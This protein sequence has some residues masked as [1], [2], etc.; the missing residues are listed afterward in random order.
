MIAAFGRHAGQTLGWAIAIFILVLPALLGSLASIAAVLLSL[1]LLP[2]LIY[3]QAWPSLARQPA[4][5]IFAAVFAALVACYGLTAR[6][7]GNLLFASSFLALP[8]A[9]LLYLLARRVRDRAQAIVLLSTLCAVG[10]TICALVASTTSSCAACR[11]PPA[12][13]WVEICWRASLS[14]LAFSALPA[15]SRGA[16]ASALPFSPDRCLPL[17]SCC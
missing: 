3:P 1:L 13:S 5:P 16:P 10:A 8:L 9:P 17:S 14:C 7:P 12:S 4:M 6:D 2:V 11:A 15:R